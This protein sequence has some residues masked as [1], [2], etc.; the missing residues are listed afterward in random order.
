MGMSMAK[1]Q[2]L[3]AKKIE[4]VPIDNSQNKQYTDKLV[5]VLDKRLK[6]D[7]LLFVLYNNGRIVSVGQSDQGILKLKS[8]VAAN[9]RK[10]SW[11]RLAIYTLSNR[12]YLND[13]EALVTRLAMRQSGRNFARAKNALD[14]VKKDMRT[15]AGSEIRVINRSLFPLE[16]RYKKAMAR[17]DSRE[18]RLRKRYQKRIEHAKDKARQRSLRSERDRKISELRTQ[19]KRLAPWREEIAR[20]QAKARSFQNIRL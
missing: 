16:R 15:W 5:S 6:K 17:F 8:Q 10:R 7:P 4:M 20:W 1:Q 3:V 19:R 12:A 11:D 2:A 18:E 13:V 14:V 9:K